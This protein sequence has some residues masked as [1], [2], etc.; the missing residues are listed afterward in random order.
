MS[1][2]GALKNKYYST[3]QYL[4]LLVLF[5]ATLYSQ[6]PPSEF[7]FN[8]SIYQSFYFFINSD[9]D[10]EPLIE[11]EDW[12]AAFNEYD[13][14]MGGLCVNIGDE[15]DGDDFTDDC[16]DVN[17]DGVLSSSVDVCVGSYDWSGEYTTIP[18]MGDDGTQWTAGYMQ[19]EQL[20]KFKIFDGSENLIYDAVPSV[21]YPWSTDLA[22]YVVNIT[23]IRDCNGDLGGEAFVDGCGECVGG[24]TGLQENYLDIGCGCNEVLVGPFYQ[25]SDNDGLGAGEE[26]YFC[27][28]PG[29]GWSENNNDPYPTCTDN[30]FDCNEDCGGNAVI[31]DCDICAGGNTGLT[32]NDEIDCNDEC[33]GTAFF[34]DC[35][36]C[37]GGSTGLEACDFVSDQPEEFLFYQS[38]LQGF[39]YV[40]TAELNNGDFISSQDWVAVFKGDVC[41]GSIKWDGPFTTIPAMGDDGSE[42]TEGYL[43]SGDEPTFKMYDASQQQFYDVET[44]LIVELV[45][46]EE[47]A[48]EGWGINSFFSVYGFVA[49]SP[50]CSGIVGGEAIIDNCGVCSGGSTGLA[51]NAD[52][53]CAGICFGEAEIDNCGVCAGGTTDNIANSDDLGCGCFLDS[54]DNY[55]A[56]IDNDG[57]GFGDI[58]S[59]C[60][61]P[62]EGWSLNGNDL[63]PYCFNEDISDLNVDEC[64]ICN[65]ENQDLDC[66][67]LCFGSAELD[68]CGECNGDNSSCL[69]PIA[70]SISLITNED[71]S[72]LIELSGSDPN[73]SELSF[74]I[75]EAPENG[76]LYGD[77]EDLSQFTYTPDS[78]FFGEDIFSFIA[79]NGEFYSDEVA[80]TIQVNAVNDA[81]VVEHIIIEVQEDID[82]DI[83]LIGSDI[84][85]NDLT[86]SLASSPLNG[87]MV[88]SDNILS[89]SP[90]DDFYGQE[91]VNYIAYDGELNSE[92][93]L[94]TIIVTA[95]N[96]KP[97]AQNTEVTLYE[98]NLFTFTFDVADIDNINDQLSIYIQDDIDFGILSV[99]GIEATLLPTPNTFGDFSII[100]QALDGELFSDPATLTVHILP[101][102]DAPEMST[103]LDQV[104]NEDEPFYYEISA[105]DIDSEDLIFSVDDVDNAEVSISGQTLLVQPNNNYNGTLI[106][107][108]SVSD[109]EFSDSESF[110]LNVTPVNDPPEISE[111]EDQSSPEDE[112]YTI[113]INVFDVDG[114]ELSFWA[115]G[116]TNADLSIS[117]NQ[118][119]VTPYQDWFGQ[120]EVSI[121]VTD[122]EYFESETFLLDITPV[123]DAPQLTQ[124]ADQNIDEDQVFSYN[125]LAVDI[126]GDNLDFTLVSPLNSIF[127]ISN[128]TLIVTPDENFNGE[129]ILDLS[130]S[131]GELVDASEFILTV[132][133]VNDPPT[134]ED[135]INQEIDENQVLNLDFIAYDVDD[136]PLVYDYYIS[137]GYAQADINN[138]VLTITPN[139]NWFGEIELS[140][141][142]SDGEYYI[143]DQFTVEVLEVD[144]PPTAYDISSITTEDQLITIDLIA[145]D[146]DTESQNLSYAITSSATNGSATIVG[147][148][149][150]YSPNLNYNGTDQ[151]SYI[152]NDGNSDS[153]PAQIDL[154][155]IPTNDPP[156]AADVEYAVGSNFLEFDLNSVIDDIDGDELDISFITQN[157]GSETISTLFDG[158][159]EHLG[160]NIFSYTP[161]AGVV[162]FDFILYKATDGVSESTVQTI[163]FT[164]LG[165]EM[166]RNMAPIAF[167]QDVSITEDMIADVTLIGFD[168]LNA[169]SDEA[170]FELTSEPEHGELSSSFTLLESGSSNLV[171]WSINYTP[172][173]N[174]FG[175]DS[176]TYRVE[177]PDNSIS[178]SEEGTI[179]ITVSPVNDSPQVF[180][181]IFDLTLLE[182][183]ELTSLSLDLFFLDV[184]NETLEYTVLSTRDDVASIYV[185]NDSLFIQPLSNQFSIPFSVSL[186]ASDGELEA[187][188]SFNIEI[189]PVND[190]P[191]ANASNESVDEDDLIAILLTG[192]DIDYDPLTYL[193]YQNPVNGTVTLN[194]NVV[195][196]E[197]NDNF[198]GE[199]SIGFKSFD[200]ELNSDL[201]IVSLTVNPVNDAPILNEIVSQSVNEDDLFEL[202]LSSDDIDGDELSY[203]AYIED[204]V[205]S[206][207]VIDNVLYVTPSENMNGQ[208]NIVIEVSDGLLT[209]SGEFILNVI[210]QPDAPEII[211]IANQENNEDENF[212]I[213]LTA[214]DVDGD[215]LSFTATSDIEGSAISIQENLLIIDPLQDYYG[216]MLVSVEVSDGIYS[217]PTSFIINFI[218]QPDPPVLDPIANQTVFEAT[219]LVIDLIASDPDGDQLEVSIDIDESISINI[220]DLQVTL[221][222]DDNISGDFEVIVSVS[223][224]VYSDETSFLLTIINVNDPPVSYTQNIILNEDESSII[225]LEAD[226]PDMD[227]LEFI[228][229]E[230][231]AHGIIELLDGV[232]TYSPE[233]NF[234]GQD[235]FTFYAFDGEE[236]SNISSIS[237]DVLPINDGPI[238]ISDPA[239]NGIEDIFYSYQVVAID[240]EDDNLLFTLDTFPDRMEIDSTGLITWTPIEGELTSGE[241]VVVVSDGGEDGVL[242]FTQTFTV[243]VEPVN[244]RPEIIS[245]PE[246]LVYEDEVYT[247]QIEVSDPDSD[248]FYYSLLIGPNG[249]TLNGDGL[250]TWIPIEGEVSSGTIAFVVWDTATPNPQFDIPAVQE[251]VVNVIPVN[252]PPSIVSTPISN[253]TEDVEYLYQIEVNDIDDDAFYFTLLEAPEGMV[254]NQNTGLI[255][256]TPTEG[257]LSSGNIS[258]IASDGLEDDMLYDIQNFAISVTPVND[259]PLILS[260]APTDAMQGEEYIYQ[261]QVEDPDD[262]EFTYILLN[263]P[264]EMNINFNTGTLSWIPGSGG[265]YGP[266][267]LKVQDGGEDFS[268]PA[269]EEFYINVQYSSGPIT[270]ELELSQNANLVSFSAI[271]N[272]NSIGNI[273][274]DSGEIIT[275]I[276]AEGYAAQYNLGFGGW[277]GSLD[278]IE[279]TR[280]YWLRA[281]DGDAAIW[282]SSETYN[283][284][285]PD[286]IPTPSDLVYEIHEDA[287]LI[288]YAGIDGVSVSDALP[289]DIEQIISSIVGQGEAATYNEVLG[290]IGSL[291]AFYRNKGYWLV[292]SITDVDGGIWSFSW[293]SPDE[294]VLFIDGKIKEYKK[295]EKLEEFK[296]TQ[297][298]KQG[299]YFIDK[300]NLKDV[301]ITSN[302][303]IIAYNG[304]VV[305]GARKW[306][307]RFTDIPA[308]GYDG[309]VSTIGY[310]RNGDMPTFKLYLDNTGELI[311]LESSNIDP[312]EDLLT[313]VV[314]QLNQSTPIPENFEFAYPYPNPFNPS[315]LIKFGVPEDSNVK[316]VAYDVSGRH[317]DTIINNRLNA[318]YYD[319]TWKPSNLSSGIYLI[320]IKTDKG[321]LT[322]KVMFVK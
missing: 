185:E 111:I 91:E 290:W 243:D 70:N 297:S 198:Y 26:Q 234:N 133:P 48:Y 266:I 310:C 107:D 283:Y 308:M 136:D 300:I 267:T 39:Y 281:P 276:I 245:E 238:V 37:V 92:E 304:N 79:F 152:V 244:D 194:N 50:D 127:T 84:E 166:P 229:E 23:V 161:P 85:G 140:L 69:S 260:A 41:V 286:A 321:N 61:D 120:L 193:I 226:D 285:I 155:V 255:S 320:N 305:V 144:D 78:N 312:W 72:L 230:N 71:E 224:G 242:P 204:E 139:Q 51:L 96:D 214:T 309:S 103:I 239:L 134:L 54:P 64:G 74:I 293:E 187:S 263:A 273:F 315:T 217:V 116:A 296:F 203:S 218:P 256:W 124:I 247:Y 121:V 119:I 137:S 179:Y 248:T 295:P 170:T 18:V 189:L 117:G 208:I 83:M 209:D 322:H 82:L 12:I 254:V 114:D 316:I 174:F 22:F 250:L 150:E 284:L 319:I 278:T 172:D 58:Q 68:D 2:I 132:N 202:I 52:V 55:Y 75:T 112:T 299:F 272:N 227:I 62:G 191:T 251:F 271:P 235:S 46:A 233:Y 199:D 206:S 42:W 101:V 15:V 148:S 264:D 49:L 17:G 231:P 138:N 307:G 236:N 268:S 59:F 131:D 57:L 200:G 106:I 240:P 5:S 102:N 108:I 86:Y 44:E 43:N 237:I 67:G 186:T 53:D 171:Q 16:Q 211:D 163:S 219:D 60:D 213:F 157:Y 30:Y 289:D 105:S 135:I 66:A 311:D 123:N 77:P 188:Q 47:L 99:S 190:A 147:N 63:E 145:S 126:D 159:I 317:V 176:F 8:I 122:G 141:T 223:D 113:D 149:I 142:V 94:I 35:D 109:G 76:V 270:L 45:G 151:I 180:S 262:D 32:P 241:I 88:I 11:D 201:T 184:D 259:S 197:P 253:A 318:G 228:I 4:I 34:D 33:Y 274:S 261:I 277:I 178:E 279:P 301:S 167:D 313:T 164:L 168:A 294:D 160:N 98:D 7:D 118:L 292:N 165:R 216:E 302:D 212:I 125:I 287:N 282:D 257:V 220:N 196:Y 306:N 115:E 221:Q 291:D 9:I 252:D 143:Q 93:G 258:V 130:V 129:I 156:T 177:N 215:D 25:D 89:Y 183:A 81:P 19:D 153:D 182:D 314:G 288:S 210:P 24:N 104:T 162:Y 29:V 31:D 3:K 28:N 298:M 97:I 128:D 181:S 56:D 21:V 246:L 95:V 222:G 169:I 225:I 195:T 207:E 38:T 146:P 280:G 158:T 303:W 40:V 6:D 173:A 192:N 73:G 36:Q 269:I 110:I 205:G 20:P 14:T 87:S 80:G 100:Y 249:L 232:V 275:E 90:N 65:G 27:S 1:F 154:E 175:D 265:V 13:E 10:G